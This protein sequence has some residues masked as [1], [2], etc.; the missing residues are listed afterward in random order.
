LRKKRDVPYAERMMG[1][2]V[3]HKFGG[4]SLADAAAYRGVAAILERESGTRTAVVVSAMS[5]MTDALLR[6]VGLASSRDAAQTA[7]FEELR[8]RQCEVAR[9]L[10]GSV[11]GQA[12]SQRIESDF[13][14]IA[15]VLRA[16]WLMRARPR[17]ALDLVS[18]YGELWSAQ[19]LR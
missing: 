8:G 13:D 11:E 5:G 18:G 2:W 12:L 19:V 3:V 10:V 15:D 7:E 14:D 1:P 9:C 16:I 6:L 17:R 4:S